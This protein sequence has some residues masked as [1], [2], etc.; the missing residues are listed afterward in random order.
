MAVLHV[1]CVG[2]DGM[3]T[4]TVRLLNGMWLPFGDVRSVVLG[5]NPGSPDPV[6]FNDVACAGVGNDLQLCGLTRGGG[7][8]HT[9]RALDGKWPF[10]FGDVLAVAGPVGRQAD[11][12]SVGAAGVPNQLRACAAIRTTTGGGNVSPDYELFET[13]RNSVGSW[14][15][16]VNHGGSFSDVSLA[17]AGGLLHFCGITLEQGGGGAHM[18]NHALKS[19]STWTPFGDVKSVVLAENPR[20]LDPGDF[21][22]VSCAGI[23]D[24]LHICALSDGHLFHTIRRANGTFFPFRDVVTDIVQENPGSPSPRWITNVSCVG[25]NREL[26]IACVDDTGMLWHTIRRA[27]TT[28]FPLGDVKGVVLSENPGSLNPGKIA[29]VAVADSF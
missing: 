22:G 14:H 17:M 9:I 6:A 13:I 11:V 12:G 4:H 28:F 29:T 10:G 20:S 24:E 25:V 16:F 15:P 26:H 8:V 7:V 5:E 2:A 18:L 1:L 3:L 19:G 23:D 21:Y 27:D